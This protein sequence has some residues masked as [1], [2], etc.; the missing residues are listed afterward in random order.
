MDDPFC[1]LARMSTPREITSSRA[2]RKKLR[3]NISSM[4]GRYVSA[5]RNS[6]SHSVTTRDLE[7]RSTACRFQPSSACALGKRSFPRSRRRAARISGIRRGVG[8]FSTVPSIDTSANAESTRRAS[9]E[10]PAAAPRVMQSKQRS[11]PSRCRARHQM[12][13]WGDTS[14]FANAGMLN[15]CRIGGQ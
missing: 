5:R 10:S 11:S 12:E 8:K 14:P 1:T 2:C 3:S 9:R 7:S 15:T 6:A 13:R 4:P